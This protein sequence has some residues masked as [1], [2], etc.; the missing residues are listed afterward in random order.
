MAAASAVGVRLRKSVY[1]SSEE[2]NLVHRA[3]NGD[4]T[5]FDA[6]YKTHHGRV[7]VT[8]KRM[9]S[10]DDATQEVTNT[11]FK[12]IWK[13]LTKFKEQ[14]KFSTWITRIAINEARMH[15]RSQKRRQRE[16]SLDTMLAENVPNAN[17]RNRGSNVSVDAAVIAHKLLASRD[18]EL[19]GVVDRQLLERAFNRVPPQLREVLRLRF[20]EG[21]SMEEIQ[22]RINVNEPEPVSLSA[23]KSRILRGRNILME[24]VEKFS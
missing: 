5:A 18:L 13:N 3:K 10:D 2:L 19:E 21:M 6:L 14:S 24:Q 16:V 9:L 22:R 23:V 1:D 4:D 17:F 7:F 8:I 12:Q 11:T 15:I 20:W